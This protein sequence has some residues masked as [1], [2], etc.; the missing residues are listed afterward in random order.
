MQAISLVVI[1]HQSTAWLSPLAQSWAASLRAA[2][3]ATGR[4]SLPMPA[5]DGTPAAART[6][7][8]S[9]TCCN[10]PILVLAAPPMRRCDRWPRPGAPV[11]CRPDFARILPRTRRPRLPPLRKASRASRRNSQCRRDRAALGGR[12]PDVDEHPARPI[13]FASAAQIYGAQPGTAGPI[14]WASGACL[15]L[16]CRAFQAIG[17]F[18]EKYFLYAEEVDLQRRLRDA[19]ARMWF[20]PALQATHYQPNAARARRPEVQ[21]YAARGMLR[22]FAKFSPAAL[23]GYRVLAMVSLR[24]PAREAWL[25]APHL[26]RPTGP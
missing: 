25:P 22:Y 7:F 21:R 8:P 19:G 3:A 11:Q 16:R 18:D 9:A 10:L 17:G 6:H 2:G 13:A 26:Q 1:T 15:L 23:A 5:T 24:L 20:D 12:F 4:W 14:D